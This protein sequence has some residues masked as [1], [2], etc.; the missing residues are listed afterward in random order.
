MNRSKAVW[1]EVAGMNLKHEI[2]LGNINAESLLKD[3][4]HLLF[5]LSRYKFCAKMMKKNLQIIEIGCGEGIGTLMFISETKAK[6]TAID[7]DAAQID[8]AVKNIQPF[9]QGRVNF[10]CRDIITSPPNGVKGNALVCLDVI[11][12][13]HHLEEG[14]FLNNCFRLVKKGGIA[15][16]GTPNK[17]AGRYAS[18]RSQ[19]GHINLFDPDRLALT[20]EKHCKNVFIFSMNDEMVHTGFSDMAHYLMALCIK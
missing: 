6:I 20:L 1:K 10:I 7:F 4:K 13:I 17:L 2:V 9:T 8:Y 18:K 5:T 11:E 15:V 16:F 14:Q 12:H 3:P 19:I